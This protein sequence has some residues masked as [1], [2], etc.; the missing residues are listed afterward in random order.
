M[1]EHIGWK[2]A[3]SAA[4]GKIG[5]TLAV[6][7]VALTSNLIYTIPEGTPSGIVHRV[8]FTQD[9]TGGHT[10]TYGG[11][12]VTVDLTDGSHTE[13]ELWPNG[14]A[15]RT[16]VYPNA[17]ASGPLNT[18]AV[19]DIVGAMVTG[20]GGTYDDTDGTIT[21]PGGSGGYPVQQVTLTADLAYTLPVGAPTDQV[22]GVVFTQD[23]IGGHTVTFAGS[24][25]AAQAPIRSTGVTIVE[26]YPLG[27]GSWRAYSDYVT[28]STPTYPTTPPA[29]SVPPV[30][31]TITASNVTS[32]GF[33]LTT[34]GWSDEGGLDPLPFSYSLDGGSTWTAWQES[35]IYNAS[36]LTPATAHQCMHRVRDYA[37]NIT[38]GSPLNVTTLVVITWA[39]TFTMGTPGLTS[40]VATASV[41]S[42]QASSYQVSYD[43]GATQSTIAPSGNAFTLSGSA[44]QAYTNT[45]LRAVRGTEVGSWVSVPSYTLQAGV[46][47]TPTYR[48]ISVKK[49]PTLTSTTWA[50]VPLGTPSATRTVIVYVERDSPSLS[51]AEDL[52]TATLTVG[53][54]A[55]TADLAF[56]PHETVV[57][58]M[59]RRTAVY[60]AVVPSGTTGDIVFTTPKVSVQ[61]RMAAW[62]IDAPLALVAANR[63]SRL[64]TGPASLTVATSEGGFIVAAVVNNNATTAWTGLPAP[65]WN[66][67][68]YSGGWVGGNGQAT[69]IS[70]TA[71]SGRLLLASYQGA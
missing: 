45:R 9:G 2:P 44:G 21:L 61:T 62:T 17:A 25:D 16:V 50:A 70:A 51:T 37:G 6:R 24:I 18:E 22:I 8:A 39:P 63:S 67:S 43:G 32:T 30:A 15:T 48:G 56:N 52:S 20:A 26:F 5:E 42:A 1:A 65:D 49:E 11:S 4:L 38:V 10:V 64:P 27:S 46:T 36:G 68:E 66:V 13:V 71:T 14:T 60:R 23:V 55:A 59:D 54:V 29:D 57:D 19:Q 47:L 35:E 53:G 28:T 41:L 58:A 34:A 40:I 7:Q 12:P 69:T 3:L 33:R 31:G